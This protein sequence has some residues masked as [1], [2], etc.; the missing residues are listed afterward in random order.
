MNYTEMLDLI[1]EKMMYFNQNDPKRIQ[2]FIKVHR[3]AQLIGRKEHLDA[4][5]QFVTECAAL[6][7]DIGIR[8]AEEKYGHGKI[9]GTGRP[10][11]CPQDAGGLIPGCGGH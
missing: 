11:V 1:T 9:A 5:T 2:H 10:H 3:F 8:P 6:V 7:H 4:H